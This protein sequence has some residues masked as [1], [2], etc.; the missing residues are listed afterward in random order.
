[1]SGELPEIYWYLFWVAVLAWI[2]VWTTAM[3]TLIHRGNM[4]TLELLRLYAEK[5]VDPPPAMDELLARSAGGGQP[6]W[7]RSR[8]GA[9]LNSFVGMAFTACVAGGILWW[10]IDQGGPQAVIYLFGAAAAFWGVSA[11][12]LLIAALFTSDK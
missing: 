6:K 5:G 8:R 7:A 4:K 3:M 10:R 2:I 1:M 11:L 9:L 12:G